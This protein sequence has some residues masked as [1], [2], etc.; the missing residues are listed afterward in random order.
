MRDIHVPYGLNCKYFG[1][2]VTLVVNLV[3]NL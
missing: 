2:P 3:Y 1:D